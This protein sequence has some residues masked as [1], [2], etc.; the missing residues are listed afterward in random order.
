M[1]QAARYHVLKDSKLEARAV[2]GS[3]IYRYAGCDYG[4]SSDD[5]RMTGVEHKAMTLSEDGDGPFFTMPV[6]DMAPL[7]EKP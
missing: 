4:C 2:A 7:G 6:T 5:A 1:K 3:V